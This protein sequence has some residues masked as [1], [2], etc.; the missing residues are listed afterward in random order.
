MATIEP[1]YHVAL[2]F[3]DEDRDFVEKVA[4][5]LR[6]D[7]V[8]VFYDAYEEADLWGKN[9]YDRLKDVYQNQALFTV[10][11]IS[12]HYRDK[13]WTNHERKAAQQ[14]ALADVGKE[15]I[16]P[17]YFDTTIT[18]PGLAKG[19][20]SISLPKKTPE[21]VANL[22]VKKLVAAG[23]ELPRTLSYSDNAK[24]DIDFPMPKGKAFTNL[25]TDLKSHDWY[26]QE[27]AIGT[28]FELDWSALTPDQIFVL[29]RNIYQCADGE[30]RSAKELLANLRRE[31]ARLPE[32]AATHLL[33]GM[34]FEV[35]FNSEGEFRPRPKGRYLERLL[36]LQEVK[37]FAS[38][39][40][41]IRRALEPYQ[42]Q[43]P[44]LP[45]LTPELIRF[46]LGVRETDPPTVKSL[47]LGRREL[48]V[49]A[50]DTHDPSDRVWKLSH[51]TFTLASLKQNLAEA[52]NIP[53][54]RI[55]IACH[56]KLEPSAKLRLPKDHDIRWLRP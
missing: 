32:E 41:F 43:L 25:L 14:R 5:Q 34:F 51:I 44:F 53:V 19:T 49:K 24:A 35:Y 23:V 7:G 40:S 47:K 26:T 48:V 21:Q 42:D 33:N 17:A 56:P 1:T 15:Y 22:I 13:L 28:I 54:T 18:L 9:L 12:E 11:F 52:W 4:A 20:G 31:L 36:A 30:E 10:M 45:S 38:S 29:G 50:D 55:E 46:K 37:K 2:S 16:L 3:A 6:S 39:I 8:E 27:P